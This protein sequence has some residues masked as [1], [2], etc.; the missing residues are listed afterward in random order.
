MFLQRIEKTSLYPLQFEEALVRILKSPA[1]PK[2]SHAN[3][4]LKEAEPRV[5][6]R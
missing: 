6:Q 3:R 1:P 5:S 4:V 2:R